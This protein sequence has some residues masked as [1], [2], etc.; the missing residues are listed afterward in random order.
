MFIN[1]YK[2][3][4]HCFFERNQSGK[5]LPF[6]SKPEL[7]KSAQAE[8]LMNCDN[9]S[10]SRDS[11]EDE[12][13]EFFEVHDRKDYHLWLLQ[14]VAFLCGKDYSGKDWRKWNWKKI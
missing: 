8:K 6:D 12:M 7:K 2:E 1:S 13:N 9:I 4:N 10:G 14:L 11:K 5:G 3:R